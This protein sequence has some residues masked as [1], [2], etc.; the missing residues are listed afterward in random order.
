MSEAGP[1]SRTRAA[2]RTSR[3]STPTAVNP[4]RRTG[5][6]SRETTP[7]T[8]RRAAGRAA[9]RATP[10]PRDGDDALPPVSNKNSKAYGSS[11]KLTG[12]VQMDVNQAFRRPDLAINNALAE[13]SARDASRLPILAED[14]V[15]SQINVNQQLQNDLQRAAPT[16]GGN[17]G[18]FED[19]ADEEEIA[20]QTAGP[21]DISAWAIRVAEEGTWFGRLKRSLLD[22]LTVI[23]AFFLMACASVVNWLMGMTAWDRARW[24]AFLYSVFFIF[25]VFYGPFHPLLDSASMR[26]IRPATGTYFAVQ[27]PV[28]P[29]RMRLQAIED[30]LSTL[31]FK[32]LNFF[33]DKTKVEIHPQIN[34]FEL[35]QGAVIDPNL[36]SPSF[37]AKD[38]FTFSAYFAALF[39]LQRHAPAPAPFSRAS[40]EALTH[41]NDGGLDRWCAPASRGKLQLTVLT[42]RP[43]AP[44]E[45]IVEHI[46]KDATIYIG[47]A[48]REIELWIDV[49]NP[50]V[51]FEV[52]AAILAS[53]PSLLD[54]SS[55]QLDRELADS[56]ALP[57]NFMLVGRFYYDINTNQAVQ[58]FHVLLDLAFLGIKSTRFA[59]RVN[60]N[61]GS[62]DATCINR[63][64]LHGIDMSGEVEV[65]EA[66]L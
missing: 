14:A 26:A 28:S 60:S 46:A 53:D 13:S 5:R 27:K 66:P 41:W 34:W 61:W 49:D 59:V 11:G 39:T 57:P 50:D 9:N 56:Q 40:I 64:R 30:Q 38:D 16:A 22:M 48:P 47:M 24:A 62:Y 63:L 4:T 10:A 6:A 37:A 55:P 51:R 52:H 1:F 19:E 44:R 45:L 29:T 42:A 65:L 7:A 17:R 21:F 58:N 54:S 43:I 32:F 36:S 25:D 33:D 12:P 20:E 15:E 18:A 3:E 31:N 23:Y 2:S 35:G 8:V